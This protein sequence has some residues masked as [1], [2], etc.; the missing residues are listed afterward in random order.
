MVSIKGFVEIPQFAD[1][2]FSVVAPLGELSDISKT[3]S[4]E[5]GIY[6]TPLAP[7]LNL[8]IFSTVDENG[9]NVEVAN[10]QIDKIMAILAYIYEQMLESNTSHAADL[11]NRLIT[12]FPNSFFNPSCGEIVSGAYDLPEWLSWSDQDGEIF[13]RVWFADAAF[14]TQY[15]GTELRL[16]M[17]FEPMDNFFQSPATVKQLLGK[18][19][20]EETIQ[21]INDT[22]GDKPQ[23]SIRGLVFEYINPSDPNDRTDVN[24]STIIYGWA[25]NNLDY[26]KTKLVEAILASSTH[27]RDEWVAILPDL[28]RR[29]EFV[30]A[31]LMN[32]YAIPE[33]ETRAGIYSPIF[34][35]K[36]LALYQ[37]PKWIDAS[38]NYIAENCQVMSLTYRSLIASVIGSPD[39][40]DGRKRITDY[41]PDY[42]AV[43]TESTDFN[44]MSL[45]TQQWCNLLNL[46][47]RVAELYSPNYNIPA[48]LS[49]VRRQNTDFIAF[50]F[51]NVQYLIPAKINF[52]KI[53]M[54]SQTEN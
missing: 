25:G 1:N 50:S 24:F 7:N 41:F 37:D 16:V 34:D 33:M 48:Q 15:D 28:F 49:R 20:T 22:I 54:P 21:K 31:P 53:G 32:N 46:A 29:T 3:Y 11:M 42:I 23:T 13:Y 52:E 8:R 36:K 35:A 10:H 51:K 5:I 45:A 38:L 47:V 2:N 30:I 19:T 39:N 12:Q 26:Q 43:N 4:T 17:P 9:I 27:S 6:T 14:R 44:R 18:I 40:L